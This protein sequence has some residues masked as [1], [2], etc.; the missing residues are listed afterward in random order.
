[1][2]FGI[3]NWELGMQKIKAEVG[4]QK[5]EVRCQRSDA[6]GRKS[7]VRR[8]E[9]EKLRRLEDGRMMEERRWTEEIEGEK[10]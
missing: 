6:R 4:G 9:D 10:L 7:E 3:G 2:E 8:F 1:M 5:S